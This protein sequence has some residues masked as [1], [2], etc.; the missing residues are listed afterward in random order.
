MVSRAHIRTVVKRIVRF[1]SAFLQIYI[2]R[3]LVANENSLQAG[4]FCNIKSRLVYDN[5]P[6]QD[7]WACFQSSLLEGRS[8]H[9]PVSC[10]NSVDR[11]R[12]TQLGFNTLIAMSANMKGKLSA[13]IKT[14]YNTGY[15]R[16][17]DKELIFMLSLI[18]RVFFFLKIKIILQPTLTSNV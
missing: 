8:P 10:A 17:K 14:L 3:C 1:S 2:F 4:T 9:S 6:T 5:Q 15:S 18:V 11:L 13:R 16:G 12:N 7:Y